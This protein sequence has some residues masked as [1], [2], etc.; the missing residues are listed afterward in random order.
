M[1]AM[2]SLTILN[3]APSQL[4]DKQVHK[5]STA[6]YL[7]HKTRRIVEYI[8]KKDFDNPEIK[9]LLTPDFCAVR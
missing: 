7:E 6:R 2:T 1:A 8:D 3:P 4:P 5:S 9:E